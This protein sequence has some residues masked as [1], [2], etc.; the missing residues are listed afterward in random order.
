MRK[1][2]SA[3][4][5][6]V[7]TSV[8]F[9]A[10]AGG[11]VGTA[12]APA[13]TPALETATVIATRSTPARA[14]PVVEGTSTATATVEP[15]P[16]V[17][18]VEEETLI[19]TSPNRSARALATLAAGSSVTVT[20]R[21]DGSWR[22]V[23]GFGWVQSEPGDYL[24]SLNVPEIPVEDWWL[25]GGPAH[26]TGTRTGVAHVDRVIAALGSGDVAA[27]RE[28][29]MVRG[30][31]CTT[32]PDIGSPPTCPRGLPD[33]TPVELFVEYACH[34]GYQERERLD[35]LLA[36][37]LTTSDESDGRVTV[38][39]IWEESL[40]DSGAVPQYAKHRMAIALASGE[41]RSLEISEDGIE[42]L[43]FGCGSWAPAWMISPFSDEPLDYLVA[44]IMPDPFVAVE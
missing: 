2:G 43:S 4:S 9:V 40:S 39:A 26:E 29:L 27:M 1:V 22:V 20:A 14:T 15:A 12:T 31:P 24:E 3:L 21:T 30:I 16:V 13:A 36:N 28:L 34:I 25:I 18:V 6:V 5:V 38:Y 42:S 19:F 10:C 32:E 44:P 33:G 11:S 41:G 17:V 7:A 37:F 23:A 35:L 8:L